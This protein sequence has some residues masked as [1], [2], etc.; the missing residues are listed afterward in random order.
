MLSIVVDQFEFPPTVY[1][2]SGFTTSLPIFVVIAL[3]YEHSGWG[4]INLSVV[5]I[6]ITFI[7]REV[8][9]A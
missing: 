3:K 1:K 6:C 8:E 4:E 7:T 2:H 9:L 5:L